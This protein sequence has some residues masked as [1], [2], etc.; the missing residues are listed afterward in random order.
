MSSVRCNVRNLFAPRLPSLRRPLIAPSTRR[1]ASSNSLDKSQLEASGPV[2]EQLSATG[3]WIPRRG[4]RSAKEPKGDKTRVNVVSEKLCDDVLS[5]IGP[6]LVR[7]KGCDLIDIYPG[8]GL[9][10]QKLHHFLKPR[11][12]I[13]MEPDAQLYEP[14]LKPLLSRHNTTL[15]PASGLVWRELSQIL[16]PDYLPR[17]TVATPPRQT[18]RNNK[19][20]VTA[21]IAFHPKKRFLGFGSMANLVLYQFIDA[22]RTSDLF[23]R[24]GLVRMLIWTRYD[25]K[26][27]LLPKVLQRRRKLAVDTELS[28]EWVNE[29]CGRNDPDFLWYARDDVINLSSDLATLRR[30]RQAKIKMP[31][32]REPDSLK[33]AKKAPW[34]KNHEPGRVMPSF[35]RPYQEE[36]RELEAEY[37]KNGFEKGS[38]KFQKMKKLQWRTNA[39]KNR[40][41][42]M[43]TLIEDLDNITA[44]RKSGKAS[45]EEIER[46]E[47]E[48]TENLRAR[49]QGFVDE[50][51]THK[52]NLHYYRQDPPLL[53][54][55]RRPYDSMVVQPEEFFPNMECSLLDIQ[56]KAMHPLVRQTGPDTDRAGDC[57]QLILSSLMTQSTIP[58]SQALDSLMPGSADYIMPRWKSARDLN[59]G[60]V[61]ANSPYS[62]LTPRMLNSKQ[63]EELLELWMEWPF[64][65]KFH[66]LVA[67]TQD[68]ELDEDSILSND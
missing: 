26:A 62:V 44:L 56:P 24:Y 22:I 11:S 12:H 9:W 2:A 46:L 37:K 58:V 1:A 49:S 25:D 17:Q 18:H 68:E 14:F 47:A 65:P 27:G 64:R 31:E 52:D 48:W 33:A 21:N 55:D 8:A 39:N 60:G 6:S 30:M 66:E 32:G 7:H 23:Q 20:L 54:W 28:C 19:L 50:L 38:E 51:I 61:L 40:Y 5:Y 3:L 15:V 42:E 35:K 57:F 41:G 67:R 63:W 29:V 59:R 4:R 43:L 53:N 36:L 10:S 13:L 16:T 45:T 34:Q